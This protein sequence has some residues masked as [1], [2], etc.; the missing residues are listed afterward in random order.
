MPTSHLDIK[1]IKVWF[2][3]DF[4]YKSIFHNIYYM[5]IYNIGIYCANTS[6]LL[7]IILFHILVNR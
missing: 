6:M 3:Y 7:I 5:T 1:P 2:A 4:I